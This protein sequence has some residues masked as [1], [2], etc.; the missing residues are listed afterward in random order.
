MSALPGA[1]GTSDFPC[2]LW[3][4]MKTE[5]S[6]SGDLASSFSEATVLKVGFPNQPQ[7]HH[8]RAPNLLEMQIL[9]LCP[10]LGTPKLWWGRG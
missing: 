1:I 4:P 6:V 9:Q 10:S 3:A 8:L 5:M 7:H 2:L